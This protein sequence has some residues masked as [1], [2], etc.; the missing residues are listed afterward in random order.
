MP[1]MDA[2]IM[3][4]ENTDLERRVLAHEHILQALI[5]HLAELNPEI[6]CRLKAGFADG[7][8]LGECEQNYTST[9]QYRE[10]FVRCVE[11]AVLPGSIRR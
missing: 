3:T 1:D 8:D 4:I 6:L 7:H 10:S 2:L 5:R 9:S 11:A